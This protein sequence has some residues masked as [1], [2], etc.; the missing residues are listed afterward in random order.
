MGLSLAQEWHIVSVSSEEWA[1]WSNSI[2]IDSRDYPHIAYNCFKLKYAKWTGSEWD[3]QTVDSESGVGSHPSIA[4]DSQGNPHISYYSWPGKDLKYAHLTG[5]EWDIQTVDSDGAV[6]LYTSIALDQQDHPH[7]SYYDDTNADLKYA[8]WTGSVWDIQTLVSKGEGGW[9]TSIALDSQ[10]YPHISYCGDS[11]N[12]R[13]KYTHWT[14]NEWDTQ[15]VDSAYYVSWDTSIAL[16]SQDN[17]HISY[18]DANKDD[19]KLAWYGYDLEVGLT[20]FNARARGDT[21]SL[22]WTVQTTEGEK[23]LGFNIY[24]REVGLITTCKECEDAYP[25]LK[26]I[27]EKTWQKVNTSPITEQ[28]PFSY[29]D[30][31]AESGHCYEYRLEAILADKN[32]ATLGTCGVSAGLPPASFAI[33]SVYP[34]PASDWLTCLLALP[35]AGT[36]ELALYDLSGRLVLNQ[37]LEVSEPTELEAILDVSMLASGVYTLQA[38]GFGTTT[39]GRAV[40][41]R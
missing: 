20:S 21:I 30:S 39:E 12:Y 26:D 10:D 4:L 18:Y 35:Q 17:P 23:I 25:R 5:S 38:S 32:P 3:I 16:D 31:G 15:I 34:N 22:S 41:A 33:L 14:G 28:N 1:G 36:V 8:R 13:L 11:P 19:L 2:S 29:T 9:Y 6:G 37:H 40:I 27:S 24:R 7:I